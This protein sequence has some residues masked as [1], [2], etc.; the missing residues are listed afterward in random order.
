MFWAAVDFLNCH[1]LKI[2]YALLFWMQRYQLG[3]FVMPT[4]QNKVA[5]VK[6]SG[7]AYNALIKNNF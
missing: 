3:C 4:K 1:F 6:W 5:L 7:R 2:C